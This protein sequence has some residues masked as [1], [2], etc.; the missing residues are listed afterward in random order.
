MK[1]LILKMQNFKKIKIIYFNI[2]NIH[3][4]LINKISI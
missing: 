3:I 1:K 2:K 4:N